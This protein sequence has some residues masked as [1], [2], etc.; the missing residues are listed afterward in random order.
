MDIVCVRRWQTIGFCISLSLFLSVFPNLL[1][2]SVIIQPLHAASN[3]AENNGDRNGIWYKEQYFEEGG[4]VGVGGVC[5]GSEGQLHLR[6]SPNLSQFIFAW[7]SRVDLIY[8][9]FLIDAIKRSVSWLFK[10]I[11]DHILWNN[12]RELPPAM[13]LKFRP[14]RMDNILL[15]LLLKTQRRSAFAEIRALSRIRKDMNWPNHSFGWYQNLPV[16]T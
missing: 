4:A 6:R 11:Y 9:E 7:C 10:E 14:N 2:C 15:L 1:R 12:K 8:L 5:V 16:K 3:Y 13:N